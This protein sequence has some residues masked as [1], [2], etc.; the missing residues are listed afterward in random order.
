MKN[1]GLGRIAWLKQPIKIR[2]LI[3]KMK[4]L[5]GMKTFRFALGNGKTLDDTVSVIACGAG[6]STGLV[7][8][9]NADFVITGEISHHEIMHEVH[10]GLSL[11]VTD[12]SNTERCFLEP[13]RQKFAKFLKQKYNEDSV[14]FVVTK[15][16][17]DPLEYI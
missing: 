5:L 10:R 9:I 3:D 17:R 15:V 4:Q 2:D 8:N 16:D 12:H 6:T 13:F 14:E 1:V 7:N 11:I